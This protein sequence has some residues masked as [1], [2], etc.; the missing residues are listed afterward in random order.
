M[1]VTFKAIGVLTEPS[2]KAG[3]FVVV[4][5]FT[6]VTDDATGRTETELSQQRFEVS[7]KLDLKA[8]C[9]AVLAQL[10]AK[11]EDAER[12]VDIGGT[13]IAE[14]TAAGGVK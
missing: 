9:E 10:K 11:H 7:S 12:T 3:K 2:P 6:Q 14:V 5:A 1:A 8:Q 4:V 13:V